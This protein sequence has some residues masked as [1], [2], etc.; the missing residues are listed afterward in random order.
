MKVQKCESSPSF[1]LNARYTKKGKEAF[2]LFRSKHP[3]SAMAID[4]GKNKFADITQRKGIKGDFSIS[5]IEINNGLIIRYLLKLGKE[6]TVHPME[7][8]IPSGKIHS[9]DKDKLHNFQQI[10]T[11]AFMNS[12]KKADEAPKVIPT[13]L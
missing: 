10:V 11:T 8:T 12:Y 6:K 1:G 9:G 2:D 13:R 5:D 3:Q 7:V 4:R